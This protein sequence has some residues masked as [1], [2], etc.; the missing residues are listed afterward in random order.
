[1]KHCIAWRFACFC[2]S[3]GSWIH[4]RFSAS[5]IPFLFTF[6]FWFDVNLILVMDII[7]LLIPAG[8]LIVYYWT[9][10]I[11]ICV[12]LCLF[13]WLLGCM[14]LW[15]A[16]SELYICAH[17]RMCM[18]ETERASCS[19]DSEQQ[20]LRESLVTGR[21]GK[22]WNGNKASC[23][24]STKSLSCIHRYTAKHSKTAMITDKRANNISL[25]GRLNSNCYETC[26]MNRELLSTYKYCRQ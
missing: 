17:L 12:F 3:A 5:C 1:M 18:C 2:N 9:Y 13:I 14:W 22:L 25:A 8:W 16:I 24:Y 21:D 7:G 20:D 23:H 26:A 4:C 10:N 19:S 6:W 11:C 15:C